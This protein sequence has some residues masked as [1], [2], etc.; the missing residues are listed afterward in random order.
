MLLP[1]CSYFLFQYRLYDN[2]RQMNP[3]LLWMSECVVLFF[4]RRSSMPWLD[5]FI[6]PGI[7]YNPHKIINYCSVYVR[8]LRV[9]FLFFLCS[10]FS[11]AI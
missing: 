5:L 9:C 6:N 8:G 4:L 7:S 10:F 11:C 3:D 2:L 1:F